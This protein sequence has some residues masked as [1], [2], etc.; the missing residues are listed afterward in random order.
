ME[1]IKCLALLS[2]GLDSILAAKMM[3]EQGLEMEGVVFMTPFSR[4]GPELIESFRAKLGIKIHVVELKQNY[5]KIVEN[6]RHGYGSQVNPCIDCKIMM[7]RAA[8]RLAKRVGARFLVTGEVLGQRPL[9]QKKDKLSLIER[10]AGLRGK[11][12]RPLSGK[13]LPETEAERMGWIKRGGMGDIQGRGRGKQLDMAKMFGV[14]EYKTPAGGCVLTDPCFARRIREYIKYNKRMTVQD[15]RWLL[16]GRHFRIGGSKVIVG[17]N[18][19]DNMVIEKLWKSAK[20]KPALLKVIDYIGPLTVVL[21]P[22]EKT[23]ETAAEITARYSDAPE[24]ESVLVSIKNGRDRHQIK[25]KPMS[26]VKVSGLI[27]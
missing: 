19:K 18:E 5:L 13:L 2:G 6:P 20:P 12:V 26:K 22:E 3:L 23:L 11:I 24:N 27:I 8:W 16:A 17:K 25:V 7:L 15:A 1:K 4:C 14:S 10:R 9:S 21:N